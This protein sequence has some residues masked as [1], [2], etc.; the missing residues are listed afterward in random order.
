MKKRQ[1][2]THKL[3]SQG[4]TIV[5]ALVGITVTVLL[6]MII[7][8]FMANYMRQHAI[9]T[10]KANLL[11]DSQRTLDSIGEDIR[12]SAAAD[13]QNRWP[14]EFTP[15]TGDLYGWHS[16]DDTLVLATAAEDEAGNII[17]ADA[18]QYISEKNNN[19][20]FVRDGNLYKRTLASPVPDNRSTT[21]CPDHVENCPSDELLAEQVQ[22]FSIRY[23]SATEDEVM[24]DEARAIEMRI[25]L[26]KPQ[27]GQEISAEYTARMVFRND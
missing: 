24:P 19:I 14:D 15:V 27:F 12:L 25:V 20:Y 3:R 17:F 13:E 4:F 5:E 16:S 6:L 26:A 9:N 10:T 11:A 7:M 23:L 18:A 8:N 21:T 1:N 22:D 2:H